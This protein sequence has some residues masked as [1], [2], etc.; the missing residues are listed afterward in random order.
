VL[1][2]DSHDDLHTEG[3]EEQGGAGR[4]T[5]RGGSMTEPS[6]YRQERCK[7]GWVV[8]EQCPDCKE[9]AEKER[10]IIQLMLDAQR[11][12]NII[13]KL[14]TRINEL[15]AEANRNMQELCRLRAEKK[16]EYCQGCALPERVTKLTEG[17]K[18]DICSECWMP[19]R[20]KE[21]EE[22]LKDIRDDYT[23]DAQNL[24]DI[25]VTVIGEKVKV[26]GPQGPDGEQGSDGGNHG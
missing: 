21:L 15:Q 9:I 19:A 20:I 26:D 8:K 7:H 23:F 10:E 24:R 18:I 6:E 4:F 25:A 22:A 14:T 2:L 11:D 13:S 12:T 5:E 16:D 17:Y 1:S 3:Q